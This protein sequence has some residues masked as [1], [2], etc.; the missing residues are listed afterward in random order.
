MRRWALITTA[1]WLP[2]VGE[3]EA[4]SP[5]RG[6][7]VSRPVHRVETVV[8]RVARVESFWEPALVFCYSEMRGVVL[9]SGRQEPSC[10]SLRRRT[11]SLG[12]VSR[13]RATPGPL[14]DGRS[15]QS[16]RGDR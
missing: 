6:R 15:H 14:R 16:W 4:D 8:C 12:C 5:M 10:F 7:V 13:D 2:Q 9:R 1:Y 3:G 11:A